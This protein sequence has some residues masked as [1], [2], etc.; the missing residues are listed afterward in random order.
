VIVALLN[1]Y[2]KLSKHMQFA[3]FVGKTFIDKLMELWTNDLFKLDCVIC[4]GNL[5]YVNDNDFTESVLTPNYILSLQNLLKSHSFNINN[6]FIEEVT[7]LCLNISD[8]GQRN[9]EKLFKS[10]IPGYLLNISRWHFK[11]KFYNELALFLENVLKNSSDEIKLR[12]FSED[13]VNFISQVMNQF[14]EY[15]SQ[16]IKATLNT[17]DLLR[18]MLYFIKTNDVRRFR[19][20][21]YNIEYANIIQ[22]VDKMQMHNDKEISDKAMMIIDEISEDEDEM[23]I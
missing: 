22:I 12:L 19:T 18:N 7:R 4:F 20:F 6:N 3:R 8:G 2:A 14:N 16:V 5:M 21:I 23:P 17:L 1:L 13:V 11:P 15:P 10:E 9:I